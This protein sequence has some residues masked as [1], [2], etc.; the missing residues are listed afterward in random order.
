MWFRYSS[1]QLWMFSRKHEQRT[2]TSWSYSLYDTRNQWKIHVRCGA[3]LVHRGDP[4]VTNNFICTGAC[5]ALCRLGCDMLTI[6]W[7]FIHAFIS[8]F[9][10][11]IWQRTKTGCFNSILF[12]QPTTTTTKS[13]IFT[14]TLFLYTRKHAPIQC[15]KKKQLWIAE[16][17]IVQRSIKPELILHLPFRV[18][19]ETCFSAICFHWKL[20]FGLFE[21]ESYVIT[22]CWFVCVQYLLWLFLL[23]YWEILLL[24]LTILFLRSTRHKN[25]RL[26]VDVTVVMCAHRVC[27][28]LDEIQILFI[29][30]FAVI[31]QAG[32]IIERFQLCSLPLLCVKSYAFIVTF[33]VVVP[34]IMES[35]KS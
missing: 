33:F 7:G 28:M 9:L 34:V 31:I 6:N 29:C 8:C 27:W 1:D 20:K 15:S 35:K 23:L 4:L 12:L 11:M 5:F 25:N 3:R 30:M 10:A 17:L 18:W 24:L 13:T 2:G 21:Y 26:S 19:G 22:M 14:V 16:E 32:G